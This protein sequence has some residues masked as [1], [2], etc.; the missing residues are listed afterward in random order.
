M[1]SSLSAFPREL[2][3]GALPDR[4]LGRGG[5]RAARSRVHRMRHIVVVG[6][7]LAGHGAAESLRGLGFDGEVTVVGEEEHR[8]YDRWPLSEAYLRGETHRLDLDIPIADIGVRWRLGVSATGLDLAA[9]E[10]ALSNG[11][12]L[13]FDGLVVATGAR[14]RWLGS[15]RGVRGTFT[16]RTIED[17]DG[18]R[19]ALSSGPRK[20]AVVGGGLIGAEVASVAVSLGHDVTL[21]TPGATSVR[22]QLGRLL[23]AHVDRARVAAG[24][25][26]VSRSRAR[27][28]GR[29][30]GHTAGVLL[31]DGRWIPADVVVVAIGTLPNVE[32]L[33]GNGLDVSNGLLCGPTLHAVGSNVVVGAGDVI[34]FP[35]PLLGEQPVRLEHW[36]STRDQARVA[37]GSLLAGRDVADH[38]KALPQFG[39]VLYGMDLRVV[40]FPDLADRDEVVCGSLESG[41]AVV[42]LHHGSTVL[43]AVSVNGAAS[44]E[45]LTD[46]VQG[47]PSR[48]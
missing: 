9:R 17:A 21:I 16:L 10:V 23:S 5:D 4:Q 33:Q 48:V 22:R 29:K 18:I 32:W 26:V 35:H 19:D 43:A 36:S 41:S 46:L 6:G 42:S 15:T 3:R 47:A 2:D 20:V 1:I 27:G 14:A 30:A 12:T 8:P 24:V 7:S 37:A 40:G 34:R 38:L 39:T 25:R 45:E 13:G 31:D 44:A 11:G 28:V